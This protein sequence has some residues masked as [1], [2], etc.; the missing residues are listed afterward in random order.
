MKPLTTEQEHEPRG[1][2]S[3]GK[4]ELGGSLIDTAFPCAWAPGYRAKSWPGR[5]QKLLGIVLHE[6]AGGDAKS[7][8]MTWSKGVVGADFIV[9][10]DGSILQ[11]ADPLL[12]APWH[13]GP[14]SP[15]HIGIEVV[16]PVT[17]RSPY[18]KA[19]GGPW[20]GDW[21]DAPRLRPGGPFKWLSPA[22]GKGLYLPPFQAQLDACT[23]LVLTLR[24]LIDSISACEILEPQA[25]KL[26][27]RKPR[28]GIVA[29]GQV[30]DDRI[31]GYGPISALAT[32][33]GVGP[34]V[35]VLP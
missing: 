30:S 10:K 13:A 4:I 27:D 15:A 16:C 1:K 23:E 31:D 2:R 21:A 35:V 20:W 18:G 7:A 11:C 9:D 28:A 19:P 14:W 33:M 17:D 29:H 26:K 5:K 3:M 12:A 22:L 24:E 34:G 8:L 32:A 25:W 6:T